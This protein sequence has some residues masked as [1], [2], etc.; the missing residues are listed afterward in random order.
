ML[1]ATTRYLFTCRSLDQQ[2]FGSDGL[3]AGRQEGPQRCRIAWCDLLPDG[4]VWRD[5]C[6]GGQREL[7]PV[8]LTA[9][10]RWYLDRALEPLGQA[11]PDHH[12]SAV[13]VAV[14]PDLVAV[15]P[16]ALD[17]R[18][19]VVGQLGQVGGRRSTFGGIGEGRCEQHRVDGID[20][21]AGELL[22]RREERRVGRC[23]EI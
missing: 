10:L 17:P 6:A 2:G 23:G 8:P 22:E 19:L 13:R 9:S 16:R 20:A 5:Q 7:A 4:G 3:I 12:E 11:A 1:L 14:H 21:A 15:S 18:M